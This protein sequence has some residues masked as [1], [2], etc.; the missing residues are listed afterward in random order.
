MAKNHNSNN[1]KRNCF[2]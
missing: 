1:S 2:L